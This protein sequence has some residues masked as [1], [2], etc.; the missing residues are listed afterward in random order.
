MDALAELAFNAG[1]EISREALEVVTGAR[2]LPAE[3]VPGPCFPRPFPYDPI[4]LA[5]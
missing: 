1:A 4:F 3:D 2:A 5:E